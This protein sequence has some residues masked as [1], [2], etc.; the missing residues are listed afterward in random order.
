M[1]AVD[2]SVTDGKIVSPKSLRCDVS[3]ANRAKLPQLHE[4]RKG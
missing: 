1:I 2:E 3:K 4:H